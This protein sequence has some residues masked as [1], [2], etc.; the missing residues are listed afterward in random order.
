MNMN[1]ENNIKQSLENFEMPYDHKAWEALSHKL[2][3]KMSVEISNS[4]KF[5]YK[6]IVAAGITSVIAISLFLLNSTNPTNSNAKVVSQNGNS[7]RMQTKNTYQKEQIKEMETIQNQS[8]D[9]VS[10]SAQNTKVQAEKSEAQIINQ[11]KSFQ[12]LGLISKTGMSNTSTSKPVLTKFN[13]PAIQDVCLNDKVKIENSN[14]E[15]LIIISPN[16]KQTIVEPNKVFNYIPSID[17]E[18]Q[19]AHIVN[20]KLIVESDFNVKSNQTAEF[21]IDNENSYN[22][23]ELPTVVLKSNSTGNDYTWM[24]DGKVLNSNSKETEAHLYK[25]GSYTAT[26]IVTHNNGCKSKESKTIRIAKDYNLL[27]VDAFEPLSSNSKI[28]TF[29]PF[30]LTR[31]DVRFTMI[32]FDMNGNEVFKTND[33]NQPWNGVDPKSNETAKSGS[34]YVWKVILENPEEGEKGQY[35]GSVIV[36]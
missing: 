19:L 33:S 17:G 23:E 29:I 16:N 31:R 35:G 22:D 21:I 2:D 25:K 6:Y 9:N 11:E 24:I 8:T 34:M 3:E 30:A 5:N 15:N 7:I 13:M 27:A 1:L 12:N 28:N 14:N 20:D 4:R 36:R 10:K 32:I 18:Y 26:L